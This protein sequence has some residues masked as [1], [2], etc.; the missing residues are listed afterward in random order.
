MEEI[1]VQLTTNPKEKP[2][3]DSSIKVEHK[4]RHQKGRRK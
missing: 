1:K 3:D 2:A 4:S